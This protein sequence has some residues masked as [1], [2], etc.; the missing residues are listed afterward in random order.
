MFPQFK[1]LNN[2]ND[3]EF[4]RELISS[5]QNNEDWQKNLLASDE[6]GQHLQEQTDLQVKDGRLNVACVRNQLDRLYKIV[7]R[8]QTPYKIVFIDISKLDGQN[9]II[10]S[11]LKLRV[12]N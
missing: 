8:K 3:L 10:G 2:V 7:L 5:I 9:P 11:L 6:I 12:R 4:Q 1:Y